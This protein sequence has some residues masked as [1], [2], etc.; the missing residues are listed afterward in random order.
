MNYI[1]QDIQDMQ[2]VLPP[3]YQKWLDELEPTT[4]QRDE[5]L[6]ALIAETVELDN[7]YKPDDNTHQQ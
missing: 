1:P 4:S 5:S 3:D 2:E 6:E 7:A